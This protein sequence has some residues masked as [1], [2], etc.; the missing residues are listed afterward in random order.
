MRPS[1]YIRAP[2]S[3]LSKTAERFLRDK[4]EEDANGTPLTPDEIRRLRVLLEK[5]DGIVKP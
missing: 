1:K 4:V 2:R 3:P 5:L